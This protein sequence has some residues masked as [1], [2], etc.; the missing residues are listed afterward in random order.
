MHGLPTIHKKEQ[1]AAQNEEAARII[2]SKK[3]LDPD[4]ELKQ[5]IA[6]HAAAKAK[7]NE[8]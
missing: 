8:Q 2:E 1:L 4:A 6:E 3:H 7:G 5:A